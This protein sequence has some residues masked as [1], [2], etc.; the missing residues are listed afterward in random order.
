[1]IFD[2]KVIEFIIWKVRLENHDNMQAKYTKIL[3]SV[4]AFIHCLYQEKRKNIL[5]K[6]TIKANKLVD[7][8]NLG[9]QL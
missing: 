5:T 2:K 1:M 3:V 6:T 4:C 9:K 8:K 7:E